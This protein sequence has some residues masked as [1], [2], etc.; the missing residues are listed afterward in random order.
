MCI[1][2]F[3]RIFLLKLFYEGLCFIYCLS[4]RFK[5]IKVLCCYNIYKKYNFKKKF[6]F[7]KKIV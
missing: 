6:V 5:L 1:V 4:L 3:E 2:V 7:F